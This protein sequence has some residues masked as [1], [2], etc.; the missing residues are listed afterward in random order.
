MRRWLAA[1]AVVSVGLLATP[2]VVPLYDGVG[3]PDQPYRLLGGQPAPTSMTVRAAAPGGRSAVVQGQSAETGPQVQ[4]DLAA[5]TFTVDAGRSVVLTATPVP[6]GGAPSDGV[7]DGNAY[8]LAAPGA[9]VS[10]SQA[11]GF[12]YLRSAVM[13]R[14]D[15]V[16]EW[17]PTPTTPWARVKT[18]R[19]GRDVLATPL[20]ALG[21]YAVVRLPGSRPLTSSSGLSATRIAALAG[22]LVLLVLVTVL[23][24]R[25]RQRL[26]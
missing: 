20:L 6:A 19:I 13:T 8:R 1:A 2:H 26:S 15:P 24:V 18:T 7:L 17:R 3:F 21:D 14:P 9:R 5:G 4:V 10:T 25:S 22:G 11:P 16:I 23:A 12:L